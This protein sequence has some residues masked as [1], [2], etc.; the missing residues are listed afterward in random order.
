[1]VPSTFLKAIR[2]K[3][4][5]TL[6]LAATAAVPLVTACAPERSADPIHEVQEL[7][8][9][10][11]G[12]FVAI[13]TA[14]DSGMKEG[15]TLVPMF[16]PRFAE[17]IGVSG[18]MVKP[19]PQTSQVD[20]ESPWDFRLLN[21]NTKGVSIGVMAKGPKPLSRKETDA[22]IPASIT[23]VVT[24]ALALKVLGPDFRFKTELKWS[25]EGSTA[26][27]LTVVADGDPQIDRVTVEDGP[28]RARIVEMARGLRERGVRKVVGRLTLLSEDERKDV[29]IHP[30]GIPEEDYLAC[31][32]AVSQNYN[33]NDNC[34][35]LAVTGVEKSKWG[36]ADLEFPVRYDMTAGSRVAVSI[37]PRF[38][39]LGR[40]EAFLVRGL[41]G[42][43]N[44]R[45]VYRSLP[46]AN[47]K[48]WFGNVLLS[49]LRKQ[50]IDVS[51]TQPSMPTGDEA[52]GLLARLHSDRNLA[53]FVIHSDPVQELVRYTNKPSHNF[54][55]DSL[56]KAVAQQHASRAADL[57]EAGA[58]AI[59]DAVTEWMIRNGH[60]EYADE[61]RLIDGAGLSRDNRAS[62]RAFL[63]LLQEFSKEPVFPHLWHSLP[64][65]GRDGTLRNRMKGTN[66]QGV[67]RAKTG[68]LRGAYQL[69]G[70]VPRL[71]AEGEVIEYVP[72]VILSAATEANRMRV[73][74]F[75]DQLVARLM[76]VVN[77]RIKRMASSD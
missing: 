4:L 46:I 18:K 11:A 17:D 10:E 49:E 45:P 1:M 56:F 74:A 64:I 26:H 9:G 63:A 67:V 14:L 16:S 71:G 38:D 69:A 42:G 20:V 47:A 25:E 13:G 21:S 2:F 5:M 53:S 41:W 28:P 72:F 70:F 40:I 32:A 62:P 44:P 43:K 19:G 66:A 39:D 15:V 22:F 57:R 12:T 58:A 75:Q 35:S 8:P 73:R 7:E 36:S 48:E 37:L 76:D 3:Q 34:S 77:P 61:I 65:A 55:A 23:K 60:P 52:A 68:T 27:D 6:V 33:F 30:K 59:H 31:Y 51:G 50:G 29:A 54:L 24:T